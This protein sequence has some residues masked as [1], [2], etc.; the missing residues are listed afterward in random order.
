MLSEF[1]VSN[2]GMNSTYEEFIPMLRQI[3]HGYIGNTSVKFIKYCEDMLRI[4]INDIINNYDLYKNDL[5]NYNRDKTSELLSSLKDIEIFKL[6]DK[7]L[8]NIVN[9]INNVGE[10]EKGCI[11]VTFVR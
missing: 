9:F 11:F 2:Y 1:I 7:Q 10:D 3:A 4:N 5:L 8:K 6:N